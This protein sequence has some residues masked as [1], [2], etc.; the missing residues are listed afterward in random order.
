[1]VAL[2][3]GKHVICDKPFALNKA[4]A[5]LLF[6][7]SLARPQQLAVLDH[8]L[9]YTQIFSKMKEFIDE[10]KL[11]KILHMEVVG[12]FVKRVLNWTWWESKD[13]GGGLLGAA[14]THWIDMMTWLSGE[15]VT[16]V[17]ANL[18]TVINK[19]QGKEVTSDDNLFV[20]LKFGNIPA[21]LVA[22]TLFFGSST[23]SIFV[24][25]EQGVLAVDAKGAEN[26]FSAYNNDGTLISK[27]FEPSPVK[28]VFNTL[29]GAGTV[30]LAKQVKEALIGNLPLSRVI[31]PT[32]KEGEIVQTVIDAI[33]ESS[34]GGRTV[35]VSY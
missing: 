12:S 14:G 17:S 28:E 15:K 20:F 33:H 18:T 2:K 7:E 5:H 8:E 13:E 29:W 23:W 25:C 1:V 27:F 21:N 9:R 6:L 3:A 4:D 30:I 32:F 16:Q 19:R 10:K 34:A 11:G 26:S 31:A 35:N 24:T 22:K